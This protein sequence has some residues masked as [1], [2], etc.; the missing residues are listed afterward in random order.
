MMF[1][2][3]RERESIDYNLLG[4]IKEKKRDKIKK[5]SVSIMLDASIFNSTL[6]A[7]LLRRAGD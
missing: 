6:L 3:Q 5:F 1:F 4:W 7:Y 2:I